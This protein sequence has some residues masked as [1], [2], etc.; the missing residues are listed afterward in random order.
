MKTSIIILF[1]FLNV[2]AFSQ[3]LHNYSV[4]RSNTYSEIP[5]HATLEISKKINI[6][7]FPDWFRNEFSL[8]EKYDLK[9]LNNETDKLGIRHYRYQQTFSGYDVDGTMV[10]LHVK[11]GFIESFNGILLSDLDD[12][13]LNSAFTESQALTKAL[14][15]INANLYKWEIEAEEQFI[16]DK[17]KNAS[18]AYYPKGELVISKKDDLDGMKNYFLTWAFKIFAQEPFKYEKVFVKANTGEILKSSPLLANA[19]EIGNGETQYS[20]TRSITTDSYNGSYR[21][22]ESVR[23]I[24][25]Y[26]LNESTYYSDA[27]DF[28]DDDNYW[29]NVNPELD[30]YAADAHWGMEMTYDYYLNTFDRDSYDGNG[31]LITQFCHYDEGY[32][33]AF[34]D[35]ETGFMVFG[36]GNGL[37][38]VPTDIIGHE[39]THG[40]THYTAN[41][42]YYAE[43]GALNE[44]FSDIFGT[45]VEFYAKPDVANWTQGEDIN[46]IVR[47]MANPNEYDDP[48]T[49]L[50]DFWHTTGFDYAGVHTNC[51]V[52]NFW[53]YLLVEGGSGTNDIGDNY[54][55]SGI[56]MDNAAAIAYRNLTTYLYPSAK[57]YDARYYSILS[58]VDLFGAC[59]PEV[60][61]VTNAWYAVGVGDEYQGDFVDAAFYTLTN[62]NCIAPYTVHFVNQSN[63]ADDFVWDF[64]DGTTSTELSPDH[65]YNNFGTYTVQLIADGGACG[66]DTETKTGYIDLNPDNGCVTIMEGV[67]TITGCSG[68]IFDNGGPYA[69]Y[70]D[71]M[72][73]YFDRVTI[74]SPE[75]TTITLF[76]NEFDLANYEHLKICDGP[77]L[78]FP[79][80]GYYGFYDLPPASLTSSSNAI[81][82]VL[83]ISYDLNTGSGFMIDWLCSDLVG[84]TNIDNK[85]NIKIYPNP[86]NGKFTIEGNNIQRIEIKDINGAAI[87]DVTINMEQIEIDLSQHPSISQQRRCC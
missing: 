17:R 20:G 9:L 22:R 39:F 62:S 23:G 28:I 63:N 85:N 32:F 26:D 30:Q 77:D 58:A 66:S 45:A 87:K 1:C 55:V 57:Y 42:I 64:G 47:N 13:D 71:N 51:G 52:Q 73:M 5:N 60:E 6:Q 74:Q 16:K 36:D 37:P 82:I 75:S 44:S 24:E 49:Y 29:N 70:E 86:T 43:H 40:V 11:N 21:L 59:S 48:D 53:F 33:N 35:W 27:V 79:S 80:I 18:A 14:D 81:T 3:V 78:N 34:F 61:A 38:L 19:D 83:Q 68:T 54:N 15:Y 46:A 4:K 69:N 8:S 76:F 12:I 72:N 25:T 50:G 7:N 10:I 31:H 56:G 41:L 2:F 67:S 84:I 65:T